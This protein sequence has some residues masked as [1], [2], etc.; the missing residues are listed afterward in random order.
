M[1]HT[2]AP[3]DD[4]RLKTI[5][6]LL[7]RRYGRQW[8]WP[9]ADP[10]EMMVGAILTQATAWSNVERAI[11]RLAQADCLSPQAIARLPLPEL[12]ELIR[13]SGYFRVKARK[14]KSLA[15]HI[16]DHYQG[17]VERLLGRPCQ[18]LR[19]ELL[20]IYGVGP[21][22]ADCI[23]L[24]AAHYPVFVIDAYTVRAGSR[25]GLFP[26]DST[27]LDAQAYFHQRLPPDPV[28]FG[29]FHALWVE[30]GKELCR[31]KPLCRRCPLLIHCPFGQAQAAAG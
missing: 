12:E 6:R 15:A 22:T 23:L 4:G 21:E 17:T 8:W 29:E 16:M 28:L 2:S 31:P 10:F 19:Q 5:Y 30:L 20:S 7:L 9:A 3:K 25:L 18:E 13:S 27:Y 26:A 14:L 1:V 24:Y 11:Q